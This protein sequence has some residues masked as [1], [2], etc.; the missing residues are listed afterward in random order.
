MLRII[1]AVILIA[2]ILP[3]I[4]ATTCQERIDF[5]EESLDELFKLKDDSNAKV[6]ESIEIPVKH[7]ITIQRYK[8]IHYLINERK[9]KIN[10]CLKISLFIFL[11]HLL[12]H[13]DFLHYL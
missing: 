6:S 4:F 3:F 5:L 10:Q 9:D 7:I 13:L 12:Y 1:G 8:G 11:N 2:F